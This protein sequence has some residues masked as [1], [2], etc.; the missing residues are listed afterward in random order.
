MWR[1]WT[2]HK[3]IVAAAAAV[4]AVA[5][6]CPAQP[7]GI[8]REMIERA[9]PLEGAPLAEPGPYQV[10][11]EHAFGSPGYLVFRPTK[12]DPFPKKD[13]L[14]VMVWGNG[15]C[16]IDSTR[17]SGFLSTIASHGFLVLGTVPQEG[18]ARRQATADDLR[19]AI[20]WAGKENARTGS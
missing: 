19:A 15:G 18:A 12:L 1:R 13:T 17:Y 11:S 4:L 7:P 5:G 3:N 9:L 14:P 16:A 20:D 8:T 2:M 6:V 10:T